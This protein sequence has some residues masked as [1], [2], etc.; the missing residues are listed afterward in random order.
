M[1]SILGPKPPPP[2]RFVV[3]R[4]VGLALQPELERRTIPSRVT[5]DTHAQPFAGELREEDSGPIIAAIPPG[6]IVTLATLRRPWNF[7]GI[8]VDP[9]DTPDLANQA[10][11]A[12][13]VLTRGV[14]GISPPL[15]ISGSGPQAFLNIIVGAACELVF[16][17]LTNLGTPVTIHN[18]R[19]TIWGMGEK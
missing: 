3:P 5:L 6:S 16:F 17:N 2:P 14:K 1:P 7:V 18:V 4:R 19:G 11:V 12:L 15:A 13:R 8:A 10:V 9:G